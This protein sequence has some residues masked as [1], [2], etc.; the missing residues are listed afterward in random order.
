LCDR[1][2]AAHF[3]KT[4]KCSTSWEVQ[5]SPPRQWRAESTSRLG[6]V[7][8][9]QH[10][11]VKPDG[12]IPRTACRYCDM[13]CMLQL[14]GCRK[15]C[16]RLRAVIIDCATRPRK[17]RSYSP[18]SASNGNVLVRRAPKKHKTTVFAERAG[19]GRARPAWKQIIPGSRS[20]SRA[21][22]TVLRV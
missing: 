6:C 15:A 22:A 9:K 5:Y 14:K 16:G 10:V 19:G 4:K 17:V 1:D 8:G 13:Y 20:S 7:A 3:T 2:V 11:S 21:A 12:T 18:V